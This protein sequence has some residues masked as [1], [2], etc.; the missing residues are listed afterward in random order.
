MNLRFSSLYSLISACSNHI[1]HVHIVRACVKHR[2]TVSGTLVA[3]V[4]PRD[5]LFWHNFWKVRLPKRRQMS[6]FNETFHV[7]QLKD[8]ESNA[9]V[10]FF[11]FLH[12]CAL[13]I[14][15]RLNCCF[16]YAFFV[17]FRKV[18]QTWQCL[19]FSLVN[20][21]IFVLFF[22]LPSIRKRQWN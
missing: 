7:S 17:F 6:I 13:F 22:F 4:L 12:F 9:T 21:V 15:Y 3:I 18:T 1:W 11:K 8:E 20:S 5:K 16:F 2:I 14:V 19:A 10:T